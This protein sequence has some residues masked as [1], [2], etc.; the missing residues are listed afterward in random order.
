MGDPSPAERWARLDW[1]LDRALEL[2]EAERDALLAAECADDLALGAEAAALLRASARGGGFLETPAAEFAAELLIG[3]DAATPAELEAGDRVGPYRVMAEIAHGGMGAVYLAERN[4]PQLRQRVAI[5]QMR[6]GLRSDYMVRRFLEERQ[7]LASLEHPGIARLLDGAVSD[8]G[9]PWFA[10]E[11][12]EGVAID[13]F[14]DDARLGVEGRVELF[15]R[16]CEAVHFAHARL[17]VHQDLKPSN[18]LVTAGGHPKLLDFGIA[19]M[20]APGGTEFTPEDAASPGPHTP[21]YA[22][23]EQRQGGPVTTAADVYSLGVLLGLLLTGRRLEGGA[24]APSAAVPADHYAAA[25]RGSTPRALRRRLQGDLDAIVLRATAAEPARRYATADEL[26]ADLRRYLGRFPVRARPATRA[27]RLRSFVARNRGG[28]AIG[29]VAAALLVASAGFSAAQAAR[30]AAERDR[31]REV[32][33][34]VLDL[35]HRSDAYRGSGRGVTVVELLRRGAA[36]LDSGEVTRPEVRGTLYFALGR[37]FTSHGRLAEAIVSLDSAYALA[38]RRHGDRGPEA[39]ALANQ[40]AD[41]MRMA[42]RYS[43]ARALYGVI[44]DA[45]RLRFGAASTEVARSL[46]GLAMVLRMEGD[47]AGAERLLREALEVDRER[48][49]AEPAALTQTLNNLGHALREQGRLAEAEALHRESL[50]RRRALWGAEHF[51]VSVSLA[52][53]AAVLRD[54]GALEA[55]DHTYRE[56]IELRLRLVGAEHPDLAA[57]QA[58][59]ARL[60]Q[61]RGD[62]V[63]AEALYRS[64]LEVQRRVLPEGHLH[65]AATL[66]GLGEVRALR[67]GTDEAHSLLTEALRARAALLPAG[68]PALREVRVA[69]EALPAR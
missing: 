15:C 67:G 48:A 64:A 50:E 4:D 36:Q 13:R 52:N 66:A 30:A 22:S 3:A 5:K 45:R 24:V 38:R 31:A 33:G 35:L 9:T 68:H 58:G 49:E 32:E 11:Y 54:R 1:L 19:R 10:M 37:A 55:A 62:L 23:P 25:T 42:G 61:L 51:E 12:V 39:I 44:L 40:L 56:A 21:E 46:N 59:Y 69:L 8:D 65:T 7:I 28:V 34:F 18:I 29:A 17:L 26:A 41:V 47:A 6:R 43:E 20:V 16:V 63:G 60:L 57:D 14:C 27:Y 2:P 53:L